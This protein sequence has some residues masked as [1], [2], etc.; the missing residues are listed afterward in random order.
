MTT[1][2]RIKAMSILHVLQLTS[3][4]GQAPSEFCES[5]QVG[6]LIPEFPVG[7]EGPAMVGV[8]FTTHYFPEFWVRPATWGAI[9][10]ASTS[11]TGT[12]ATPDYSNA[13]SQAIIITE[14]ECLHSW[15]VIIGSFASH[16]ASLGLG[17]LSLSPPSLGRSNVE[18]P[19]LNVT[20]SVSSLSVLSGPGGAWSKHRRVSGCDPAFLQRGRDTGR[21]RRSGRDRLE[22]ITWKSSL[23]DITQHPFGDAQGR[24]VIP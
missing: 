20:Q 19:W 9:R 16:A 11:L 15:L 22:W 8:S 23:S 13:V 12:Q 4:C 21:G 18:T 5:W 10:S 7:S 17:S 6:A 14:W 1:P 24:K 3:P 2:L